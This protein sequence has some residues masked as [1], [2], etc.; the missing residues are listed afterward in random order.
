MSP[1]EGLLTGADGVRLYYRQ[2][3]SGVDTLVV[4]NAAYM[5]D[6]FVAL[7][8][9]HSVIFYDLR[10]RGRSDP[11]TDSTL[12]SAIQGGVDDLEAARAH[13]G[14]ERISLLAHSSVCTLAILYAA[15]YADHVERVVLI[16]PAPPELSKQYPPHLTGADAVLREISAELAD[17]RAEARWHDPDFCEKWGALIRKL[18][19]VDPAD[20]GKINWDVRG[21]PNETP[22]KL[23]K[24]WEAAARALSALN[25]DADTLAPVEMPVL[26]IHGRRDRQAAYGGARD[27]AMLLPNARLVTVDN[28]AHLPWIEA[29]DLVFGSIRE[30]LAGRWPQAARAVTALDSNDG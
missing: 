27:W 26:I 1:S 21:L 9:D 3:G 11:V 12:A 19:V 30:F 6:D 20:A 14:V 10:N 29:P 17:L 25:I 8:D 24:G 16:G 13:F 4:P 23:M 15:Q 28:G 2:V 18:F 5:F 22:L 7:A